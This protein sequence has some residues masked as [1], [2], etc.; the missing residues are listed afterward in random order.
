MILNFVFQPNAPLWPKI[1]H[2]DTLVPNCR[3]SSRIHNC[4]YTT[5]L[6]TFGFDMNLGFIGTGEITSSIV[7]GLCSSV[8]MPHSIRLSPRNPA[9]AKRLANRFDGVSIS[10]SN[11]EVLDQC[12]T[13][14]I[15]VRPQ[16]A[17]DVLS[18]LHF[19]PDHQVVSLVSA[20]SLRSVS[21]IV[22]PAVRVTRAV[23]LPSTAERLRPT[24][25]YPP[26]SAACDLFAALGTVFAVETENEFDAMCAV[27][28]TIAAY[29]A[30]IERI[31]SWLAQHGIPESKARDH[32][33]RMFWGLTASAVDGPERSFQS[34]ASNHATAGGINEQ[35]LRYLIDHGLLTNVSEAL[36]AV[37][38]RISSPLQSTD[39]ET[40]Y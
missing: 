22:A 17:R 5:N 21:E 12:D 34:L 10:S 4:R 40:A 20:L 33:A 13:I 15:A 39:V 35:F 29:F 7:T 2:L 30:F 11:Q 26:E 27:T 28:A 8:T 16:V 6:N 25:I 19:R 31:G 32:I 1:L 36:D 38:S 23:P 3:D 18:E 24:G 9:I 14:V 37:L